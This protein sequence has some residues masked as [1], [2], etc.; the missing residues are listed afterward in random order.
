[1]TIRHSS[2]YQAISLALIGMLSGCTG[3]DFG[4]TSV[5]TPLVSPTKPVPTPPTTPIHHE[6]TDILHKP[7]LGYLM[8]GAVRSDDGEIKALHIHELQSLGNKPDLDHSLFS[9]NDAVSLTGLGDLS[10]INPK[11]TFSLSQTNYGDYQ[12]VRFGHLIHRTHLAPNGKPIPQVYTF[13]H[14]DKPTNSLPIANQIHYKGHWTYMSD[15]RAKKAEEDKN[16]N[17][18]IHGADNSQYFHDL[19]DFNDTTGNAKFASATHASR[20]DLSPLNGANR[21][22][23]MIADFT[24][25]FA[26]K[27]LTGTLAYENPYGKPHKIDIRDD[28]IE[29]VKKQKIGKMRQ[30]YT[31]LY[32][33]NANINQNRFTGTAK[34]Q[35]QNTPRTI[36]HYGI[37]YT[38][39]DTRIDKALF[40]TD[41]V[42]EGGFYGEHGAELVGK[43]IT[44]NNDLMGVFGAKKTTATKDHVTLFDNIQFD[45]THDQIIKNSDLANNES[46]ALNLPEDLITALDDG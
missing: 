12:H 23:N 35:V 9:N 16:I 45:P 2:L 41:G 38:H 31:P 29:D 40:G 21:Y 33:I 28:D 6:A 44:N 22:D 19:I 27:K 5:S 14:G 37:S 42:V 18:D 15:A 11:K 4:T 3:G 25:D 32:H 7:A 20:T 43:F 36:N 8:K 24:V 13:Y 30:P 17:V 10:V 46:L 26:D 34:S 39:N 1:M